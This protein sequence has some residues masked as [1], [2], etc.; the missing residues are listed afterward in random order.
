MQVDFVA[1]VGKAGARDEAHITSSNDRN[2]H[3]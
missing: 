1:A 3:T 2:F